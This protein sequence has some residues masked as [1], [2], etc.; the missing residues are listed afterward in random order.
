MTSALA[1]V[2]DTGLVEHDDFGVQFGKLTDSDLAEGQSNA[3]APK[4]RTPVIGC[5]RFGHSVVGG[6]CELAEDVFFGHG[7]MTVSQHV[8]HL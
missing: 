6:E 1:S 4:G 2:G 8:P 5:S 3:H 7:T